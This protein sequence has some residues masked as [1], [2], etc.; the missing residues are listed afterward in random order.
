MRKSLL[1]LEI[2]FIIGSGVTH[3][4]KLVHP[5]VENIVISIESGVEEHGDLKQKWIEAL[6]TWGDVNVLPPEVYEGAHPLTTAESEWVHLIMNREE[7]WVSMIDSL[8]IPF[9][10]TRPPSSVHIIL[11]NSGGQ[12]AFTFSDSTIG[13]DVQRLLELYGPASEGQNADRIDRFFAHEFTHLMHKSW[14]KENT[15]NLE[16]PLDRALW[17]CLVEGLGNYRSLSSKWVSENG[18][19]TEHALATLDRLQIVF[20]NRLTALENATE[21][22]SAALMNGLSMG[23]FDQKWGALTV[24]LWLARFAKGDEYKLQRWV[25]SGPEGILTLAE[26]NLPAEL[27]QTLPGKSGR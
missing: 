7:K 22:E 26:M 12:D 1:L 19:L 4:Q 3:A 15:V 2:F 5:R 27:K 13:F 11:G 9:A 10:D 21:E 25:E 6:L 18:T 23:P 20:V 16:T 8:R 24:A 17:D 14:R